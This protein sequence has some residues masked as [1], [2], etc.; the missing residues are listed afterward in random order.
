MK[1]VLLSLI[2]CL[3]AGCLSICLPAPAWAVQVQAL[4]QDPANPQKRLEKQDILNSGFEEAVFQEALSLLPG[5]VSST[6]Q[7]YLREYLRG[8]STDLVLSYSDLTP[9]EADAGGPMVLDV[10]VNREVLKKRLQTIGIYYTL[11]HLQPCH[12]VVTGGDAAALERV[13]ILEVLTGIS[14]QSDVEP[15]LMLA[16]E[17]GSWSGR[18]QFEG[19]EISGRDRSLDALWASLWG[20]FFSARHDA[21]AAG[22]TAILDVTGWKTLEEVEAFDRELKQ[23]DA[24]L[25][26]VELAGMTVT[27]AGFAADWRIKALDKQ[28][29]EER[30]KE[31]LLS[32]GLGYT[33]KDE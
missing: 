16:L 11:S 4:R 21:A 15:Q 8:S 18:I 25:E 29:L 12:V 5:A 13:G 22:Q 23:W 24:L 14:V 17:G 32:R 33:V 28:A 7:S 19:R 6:R 27:P 31:Y 3:A 1:S 20:R 10:V 2:W 26:Q 9:A 30:L